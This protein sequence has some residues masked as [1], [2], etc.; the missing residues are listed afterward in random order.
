MPETADVT[1]T[2]RLVGPDEEGGAVRF[3]DFRTFCDKMA[4]CLRRSEETVTHQ[5][6][7]IRYRLVDLH[8][9]SA[10]MTLEAV[11]P[12]QSRTTKPD[13][14]ADVLAFFKHTVAALEVSTNHDPK[15]TLDD[16]IAFRDLRARL[17][18][19][20][21]VWVDQTQIT[22]QY[23]ANIDKILGAPIRSKGSVSGFLEGLN[24]HQKNEFILYPPIP[25]YRIVCSFPEEMFELVRSALKRN[26]TAIG[27]LFH[28]PDRPFPDRVHV[29][30]LEVHPP[31]DQLPTLRDLGGSFSGC[32]GG[33]SAVDFVRALRNEQ[34]S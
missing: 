28:H 12:K 21:E 13:R 15:L 20:K 33:R 29:D 7:K 31:N 11:A 19:T 30:Q 18:R 23:V 14:R 6:G 10:V 27:T 2:V 1:V 26:V 32:T 4:E 25:G 24:V 16:L 9:G 34:E 5:A 8:G 3:E 22:F 17:R